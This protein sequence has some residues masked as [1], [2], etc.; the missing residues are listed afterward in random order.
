M[1]ELGQV[2]SRCCRTKYT[3]AEALHRARIHS[4]DRNQRERLWRLTKEVIK[5]V[6]VKVTG[7]R[8]EAGTRF[9]DGAKYGS[10]GAKEKLSLC[11]QTR[12]ELRS[13]A[14]VTREHA[15]ANAS[16]ASTFFAGVRARMEGGRGWSRARWSNGFLRTGLPV[17]MGLPVCTNL[18]ASGDTGSVKAW[19]TRK[20]P[21]QVG[22]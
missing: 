19:P 13:R 8:R 9:G 22:C 11:L 7:L 18:L 15:L 20:G 14:G 21:K 10:S 17:R 12:R 2:A 1:V 5:V 4:D 6:D 3:A 16:E